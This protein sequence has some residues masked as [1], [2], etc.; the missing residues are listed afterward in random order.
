MR[1]MGV[2]DVLIYC[3]DYRCS[4]S[5]AISADQWPDDLRLSDIED[6]FICQACG[7][8]GADIRPDFN[9]NRT[10]VGRMGLPWSRT[11]HVPIH[12]CREI[13]RGLFQVPPLF[14]FPKVP[15]SPFRTPPP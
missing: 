12:R 10:A 9:W 15:C 14:R 5:I 7:K 2:R 11:F 13:I 4:H 8:R 6:R 1:D 3:A